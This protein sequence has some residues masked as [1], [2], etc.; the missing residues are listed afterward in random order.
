MKLKKFK[1][2]SVNSTNDLA[3]KIIKTS[4]NDSGIV[5]ADYQKKGRGR[6]GRKW[7]SYKG[8]LFVTIFFNISKKNISLKKVTYMN[9][10]LI[11]KLL[12]L[13][14]KKKIEI[15]YPNDLFINKGKISGILQEIIKKGEK[16]F[17]LI[18]VGIN[19][20]KNP[21]IK[22]CPSTNLENVLKKKIDKNQMIE[23][24]RKMYEIFI[25]RFNSRSQSKII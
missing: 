17:I 25:I 3:I 13:Y 15:K 12:S 6:Y 2:K 21:D 9:C 19:L 20:V 16:K 23:R 10:S 18:G 7:I 22:N 4:N 1:Y 5:I 14:Y 24:L 8:N 11:K